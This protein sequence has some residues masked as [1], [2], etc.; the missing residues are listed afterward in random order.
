MKD[1]E[2]LKRLEERANPTD[3][4]RAARQFER[5]I[6]HGVPEDTRRPHTAPPLTK[7]DEWIHVGTIVYDRAN[8][9]VE[10]VYNN[11]KKIAKEPPLNTESDNK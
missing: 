6:F 5:M 8:G 4:Y 11:D 2:A 7:E 3:P 10:Y 1:R 9:T